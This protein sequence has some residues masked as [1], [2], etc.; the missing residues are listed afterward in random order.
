M[1]S[2]D[3]FENCSH[4]KQQMKH[5]AEFECGHI[6]CTPCLL[7]LKSC[8]TCNV[9]NECRVC[10]EQLVRPTRL[11]CGHTYC[12]DCVVTF[13][14]GGLKCPECRVKI[15]GK[16]NQQII[17]P[18]FDSRKVENSVI[19]IPRTPN[20]PHFLE[21]R[22]TI[23]YPDPNIVQF[24]GKTYMMIGNGLK[25]VSGTPGNYYYFNDSC[26]RLLKVNPDGLPLNIP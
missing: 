17:D 8:P 22:N 9:P 10:N 24:R 12:T 19:Q 14:R 23:N 4:C 5:K 7:E 15:E 21:E 1:A 11:S 25:E 13:V 16:Q 6:F 20:L 2:I 18:V 26:R 3:T